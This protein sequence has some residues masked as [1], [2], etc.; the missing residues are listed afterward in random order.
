MGW[1]LTH[2]RDNLDRHALRG[3]DFAKHK[4]LW[5]EAEKEAF[6]KKCENVPAYGFRDMQL[7]SSN[8]GGKLAYKIDSFHH[9]VALRLN[10]KSLRWMSGT[11]P[12]NRRTIV[13]GLK[14]ILAEGINYKVFKF[15]VKAFYE[16]LE[17]DQIC[18]ILEKLE[19]YPGSH[20]RML[21]SLTEKFSDDGIV[22]LPRGV[23]ISSA[24]AEFAMSDF[25]RKMRRL[26]KVWYYERYVDDLIFV[27]S[28][29][30][31]KDNF[32][33]TVKSTLPG[34]LSMNEGKTDDWTLVEKTKQ[35]FEDSSIEQ[36]FSY[37]GY[38]M[39]VWKRHNVKNGKGSRRP[40]YADISEGKVK[41]IKSRA[42][43]S[44]IVYLKDKNFED[45]LAR[46]RM[47]SG[48]YVLSGRRRGIYFTYPMIDFEQ[49]AALPS[50]DQ[51]I[52]G[53][54]FG[55]RNA[56]E[57]KVGASLTSVQ[58]QQILTCNFSS[59]H[60]KKTFWGYSKIELRRLSKC[61]EYL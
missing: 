27:T 59:G 61:W 1:D 49:S 11:R 51:F 43:K 9:E 30:M 37:L 57:R 12:K 42:A 38:R 54:I 34:K 22:G 8:I 36:D 18:D 40:V 20:L 21:R 55:T 48:N 60:K 14:T 26:P 5:V 24:L 28:A 33:Q 53:L 46:L 50:I 35:C 44:F 58:K 16:S 6:L 32:I 17:L 10:I 19:T 41:K 2:H 56:L 47:L 13:A 45:L 39:S 4:F 29:D 15:D 31:D 25:D 7:I 23:A 52:H 3:A